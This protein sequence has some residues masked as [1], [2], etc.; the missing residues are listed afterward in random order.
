MTKAVN[1]LKTFDKASIAM[2]MFLLVFLQFAIIKQWKQA[3]D[4]E[5]SHFWGFRDGIKGDNVSYAKYKD[6]TDAE[7]NRQYW[8]ECVLASLIA[9]GGPL[10]VTLLHWKFSQVIWIRVVYILMLVG[11]NATVIYRFDLL[12]ESFLR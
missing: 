6:V 12:K 4:N 9:V 1:I 10:A 2:M 11:F 3:Y 7:W 8:M 5:Y